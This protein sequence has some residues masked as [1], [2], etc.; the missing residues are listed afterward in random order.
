MTGIGQTSVNSTEQIISTVEIDNI[1]V[2]I[3]FH[4]LPDSYLRY[5]IM[6]GRELLGQG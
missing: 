1:T 3:L 6:V 5:D 4:V 2:D